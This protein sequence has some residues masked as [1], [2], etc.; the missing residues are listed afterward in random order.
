MS[1]T[2]DEHIVVVDP[3]TEKVNFYTGVC[4]SNVRVFFV[5]S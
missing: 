5:N 2:P 1:Y 3:E 4:P